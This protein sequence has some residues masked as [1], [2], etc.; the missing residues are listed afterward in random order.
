MKKLILM[1]PGPVNVTDKV[2]DAQ[3]RGDL[4]HRESE[5][6]DLMWSIRNKLLQAFDIKEEYSAILIT[7]SGTA[8]LEMAVSS[9]LT[10]ERSI[11]VIQ[12]GAYGERISKMADAYRMKKHTLN[13]NWGET[14]KLNEVEQA[15]QK[16]SSIEVIAM[17][18]HETTTGLLNPLSEIT[19]LAKKYNKRLVIDCISSL[20]GDN[21][22][23][24]QS[25]IDFAVG[26][27]NKCIHGLP[28]VSFVLHRKKDLS[29]IK[30]IPARSIYFALT[31]HL[32]AQDQGD[33]LF[34]PAIQAH[35]ALNTALEEL[36]EETVDGRIERYR[37]VAQNLR[38]GFKE[39]GLEFLISE[40]LQSNC[41]TALKLPNGISYDWLH[42]KLKEN[43]F[44]I[45]AGQGLFN[46]K[47][48]RIANMGNIQDED[49]T[50]C[51]KVLKECF[52]KTE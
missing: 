22:N 50:R 44:I 36:L 11:L 9:C 48:F 49:F 28:G 15:L 1:N 47:I 17:V 20:G 12:N 14:P 25:P 51:L 16:N 2:R 23:F 30:D 33:T 24:K 41:L 18:H 40:N 31:Q 35:Y 10:P 21:I 26:T 46:Q 34:T 13:Y 42:G 32:E 52:T 27:A 43:G 5:F 38:K 45:Y 4:C 7:G 8:A 6:S 39:I 29:R 37:K 19:L 3:L